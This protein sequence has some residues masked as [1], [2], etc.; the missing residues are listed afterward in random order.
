MC[1]NICFI[2]CANGQGSWKTFR[3]RKINDMSYFLKN[4]TN[5]QMNNKT[6][7]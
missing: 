1:G 4:K 3:S 5:K 2:L 7:L 6:V